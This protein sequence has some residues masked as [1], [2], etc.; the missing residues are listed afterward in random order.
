M[1]NIWWS[2]H[3]NINHTSVPKSIVKQKK[4]LRKICL[5]SFATN[6]DTN[7]PGINDVKISLG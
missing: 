1:L 5:L 2:E 7:I 3:G 6:Q 4:T